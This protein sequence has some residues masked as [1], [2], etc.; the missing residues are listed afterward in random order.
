MSCES[1]FRIVRSLRDSGMTSCST[2]RTTAVMLGNS[3]TYSPT[4]N[5]EILM[6][7][8]QKPYIEIELLENPQGFNVPDLL[9]EMKEKAKQLGADAILYINESIRHHPPSTTYIPITGGY[10][11]IGG[12]TYIKVKA[13]AI[14]YK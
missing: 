8:P 5:I 13:I 1:V 6:K 4:N 11:S 9:I 7:P 2:P 3:T 12:V 14:K 10:Q